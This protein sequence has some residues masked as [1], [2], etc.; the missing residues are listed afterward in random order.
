MRV[1]TRVHVDGDTVS[2]CDGD[3]IGTITRDPTVGQPMRLEDAG[4]GEHYLLE[5]GDGSV[6]GPPQV[7]T[8]SYRIGWERA[9]KG[10]PN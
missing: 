10:P 5:Y 6:D 2:T 9:F 1:K 4:D 8:E 3:L 7:A